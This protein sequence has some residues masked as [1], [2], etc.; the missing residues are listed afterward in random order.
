M[1]LSKFKVNI[2]FILDSFSIS[3]DSSFINFSCISIDNN[4]CNLNSF[5]A[6]IIS[7]SNIFSL[8]NKSK[9]VSLK[10]FISC[11]LFSSEVDSDSVLGCIYIINFFLS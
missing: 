8:F 3:N 1:T 11:E 10:S 4:G 6:L 5:D 7:F 9:T 2:G